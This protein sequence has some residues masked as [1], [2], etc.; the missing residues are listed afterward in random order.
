MLTMHGD[1]GAELSAYDTAVSGRPR[2][3]AVCDGRTSLH[4]SP[5]WRPSPTPPPTLH[6]SR[7]PGDGRLQWVPRSGQL[8]PLSSLSH[9]SLCT[10]AL[11]RGSPPPS[12]PLTAARVIQCSSSHI[13]G[14]WGISSALNVPAE[15]FLPS[16]A[17]P[18]V[19][20]SSVLTHWTCRKCLPTCL[21][22]CVAP[23]E[24]SCSR[25]R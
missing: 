13:F 14:L 21:S 12:S 10:S 4:H 23:C 17:C 6:A 22:P 16:A 20:L 24:A 25:T 19:T 18:R 9:L 7:E 3:G 8:C 1:M 5:S 11:P 2:L 15:S